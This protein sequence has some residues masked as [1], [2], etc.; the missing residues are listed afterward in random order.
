[1]KIIGRPAVLSIGHSVQSAAITKKSKS[2]LTYGTLTEKIMGKMV[3]TVMVIFRN[4][5]SILNK[6]RTFSRSFK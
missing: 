6:F 1:M 2:Q 3:A 4:M 5:K